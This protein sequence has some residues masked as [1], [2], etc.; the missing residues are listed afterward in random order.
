[1]SLILTLRPEREVARPELGPRN[2]RGF[3][4]LLKVAV[5]SKAGIAAAKLIDQ[6]PTSFVAVLITVIE[7]LTEAGSFASIVAGTV[8]VPLLA[9][10]EQ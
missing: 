6:S 5:V 2:P 4:Q 9:L 8:A 7:K 3:D 1:M 10:T